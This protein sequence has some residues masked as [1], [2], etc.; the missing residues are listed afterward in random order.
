MDFEKA[1]DTIDRHRMWQML[2]MYGVGGKGLLL[3]VNVSLKQ[4][5]VISPW[6]FNVYMDVV[7]R[8]VNAIGCLRVWKFVPF[9]LRL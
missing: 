4:G 6:L 7:V 2:R 1:N 5:C 3:T 9:C 8:K